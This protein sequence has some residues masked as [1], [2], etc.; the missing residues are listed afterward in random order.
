MERALDVQSGVSLLFGA[1][2]RPD[3]AAI[4]QALQSTGSAEVAGRVSFEPDAAE[5]W[6]ELISSGLTF[7]LHGLAPAPDLMLP[8]FDHRVGLAAD[9][10]FSH[11]SA[12]ALVPSEHI[13][14]GAAL[15]PVVR[16]QLGLA[17]TLALALPASAVCWG[18]AKT[19]MEP[20]YF[21]RI[22]LGWLAGGAFPALGLTALVANA[23]G[24]ISSKGLAYFTAQ[25][26]QVE[27]RTGES[28][29]DTVK[30]AIR[31]IDHLV[32][33]GRI[34]ERREIED[35]GGNMI[36]EPSQVGRLVWIWRNG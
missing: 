32:R 16:T 11:L 7:D 29:A 8:Q 25:E 2:V 15:A 31:V 17:A 9:A 19:A 34:E 4:D 5:G 23:D 6:V 1:D 28:Q 30:A 35:D 10:D 18:P 3:A 24:S 21:A 33:V 12:V 26:V 36:A 13:A 22:V 20:Q 14:G 27:G